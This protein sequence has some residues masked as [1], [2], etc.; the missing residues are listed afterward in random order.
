MIFTE[1]E[2]KAL[3]AIDLILKNI[4][5]ED[6]IR[7]AA[8]EMTKDS[9]A[10]VNRLHDGVISKLFLEN[11]RL[12]NELRFMQGRLYSLESDFKTLLTALNQFRG[13]NTDFENLKQ[14]HSIY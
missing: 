12:S 1:Q 2:K 5:A 14:K 6:P 10:G 7:T 9:L 8:E 4:S 11:D 3:V 13:Y